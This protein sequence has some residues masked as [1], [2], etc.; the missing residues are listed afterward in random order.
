MPR[1]EKEYI[2]IHRAADFLEPRMAARFEQST[3][4]LRQ[5][6]SIN[7]LALI[8]EAGDMRAIDRWLPRSAVEESLAPEVAGIP[9]DIWRMMQT[10]HKRDGIELL[11]K[12]LPAVG[13]V[14]YEET[15]RGTA[16]YAVFKGGRIGA[17]NLNRALKR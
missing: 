12:R 3:V 9:V 5:G 4:D 17:E 13:T 10:G 1:L 8:I 16:I 15:M 11:F 7:D 6:L 2:E 14:E